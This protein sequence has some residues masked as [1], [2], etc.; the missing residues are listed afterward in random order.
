MRATTGFALALAFVAHASLAHAAEEPAPE[1][2]PAKG[3]A[4]EETPAKATPLEEAPS[5]KIPEAAPPPVQHKP[6][7]F[8][9]EPDQVALPTP[10]R[11]VLEWLPLRLLIPAGALAAEIR[12]SDSVSTTL[13]VGYGRAPVRTSAGQDT[14]TPLWQV[15]L[16]V[17]WYVAGDFE[18]GGV[19]LG[20][21]GL[22][23]RAGDA[24]MTLR[25]TVVQ[26]GVLAGP[27][28]G[29]KYVFR[30]RWIV[31]SQI[32]I[33]AR[34]GSGGAKPAEQ[35]QAFALLGDLAVGWAF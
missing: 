21:S 12:V 5:K 28:L 27:L 3:P 31:D 30:N 17:Q 26:P 6:R 25:T 1:E 24:G 35:D 11:V 8:A 9:S 15:G 34:L 14:R 10:R 7:A 18:D 29:F 20:V 32:G 19:H 23:S 2:T 22:L 33:G 4:P 13:S 16:S